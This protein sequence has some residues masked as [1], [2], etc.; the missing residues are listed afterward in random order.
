M[1]N[2]LLFQFSSIVLAVILVHLGLIAGKILPGSIKI[3]VVLD[4]VLSL[5]F[6]SGM[7]IALP[8][9]KKNDKESFTLRFL[10]LTSF[11]LLTVLFLIVALVYKK[12]PSIN[13]WAF[14]MVSVFLIFLAVQSVLLIK[15]VNRS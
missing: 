10:G 14:T 13:Y 7:L 6:F 9:L 11:Q 4:V 15:A 12:M 5:I 3:A 1:K 8:A 2:N